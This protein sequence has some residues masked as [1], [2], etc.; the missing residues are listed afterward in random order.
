MF[1]FSAVENDASKCVETFC[2]TIFTIIGFHLSA[3]IIIKTDSAQI[4]RMK[5]SVK[6]DAF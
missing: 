4:Q 5:I 3:K 2:Y 1:R 6:I